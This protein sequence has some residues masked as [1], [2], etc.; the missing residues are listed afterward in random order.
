MRLLKPPLFK[1]VMEK[2]CLDV[3]MRRRPRIAKVPIDRQTMKSLT[4]AA[5]DMVTGR[6]APPFLIEE[7]IRI[8]ESCPFGGKRCDLCGCFVN[9]KASLLNSSCPMNK[10]PSASDVS[11]NGT[12]HENT[13]KDSNEVVG[14]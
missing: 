5:L 14:N 6:Y 8:C 7:R 13:E 10:W 12:Q 1:M 3:Y 9:G 2:E 4:R 11:V